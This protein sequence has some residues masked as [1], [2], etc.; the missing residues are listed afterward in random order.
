MTYVG[1]KIEATKFVE[2]PVCVDKEWKIAA[3]QEPDGI[4]LK[5]RWFGELEFDAKARDA[6]HQAM[7]GPFPR[8]SACRGRQLVNGMRELCLYVRIWPGRKL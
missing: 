7:F 1:P 3:I 2:T 8:V 4:L 6:I 5:W